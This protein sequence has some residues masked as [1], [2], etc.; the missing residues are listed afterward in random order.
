[1]LTKVLMICESNIFGEPEDEGEKHQQ[2]S[3]GTSYCL[4]CRR[5]TIT[6]VAQQQ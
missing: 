2:K 1:M 5:R 4:F 3:T 6:R